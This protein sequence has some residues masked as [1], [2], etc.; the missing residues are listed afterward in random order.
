MAA[1]RRRR[2]AEL[3]WSSMAVSRKEKEQ[4]SWLFR[5][6]KETTFME[7]KKSFGDLKTRM[8]AGDD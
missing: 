7:E 6:G 1:A 2:A 8:T 3:V 4:R 5:E